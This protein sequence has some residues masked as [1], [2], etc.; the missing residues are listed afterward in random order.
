MRTLAIIA[1]STWNIY[2]FRRPLLRAFKDLGW[3]VV[4]V[5]PSDKFLEQVP[6]HEFDDFYPLT[7]L[8]SRRA[9]FF[10][11]ISLIIELRKI[12]T[13][14]RPDLILSFTVKPNI[15]SALAKKDI[16]RQI[17]TVTGLGSGLISGGWRASILGKLYKLVSG[18]ID[19]ML[20]QNK[21]DRSFFI[22]NEWARFEDSA[23]VAGSGIDIEHF[24]PI[25]QPKTIDFL[26]V[27]RLMPDKGILEFAEAA[28]EALRKNDELNFAAIGEWQPSS[29][30]IDDHSYE[31][32]NDSG[33]WIK[34]L[35]FQNDIR[36][37]LAK[38]KWLV[39]PSRREG[40]SRAILE[41]LAMEIPVI[42]SD[43]PG[44]IE[45]IRNNDHGFLVPH[46]NT[47]KLTEAMLV[48]SNM[49]ESERASMG[50]KGRQYIVDNYRE[51]VVVNQY[52]NA[53]NTL[54]PAE[55]GEKLPA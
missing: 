43:V 29:G 52:L 33:S 24:T 49:S 47:V 55:Q 17:A 13:V 6:S 5:A 28:S 18:R 30:F 40:L 11:D 21:D 9:N 54:I 14:I 46:G 3:K 31:S 27:G 15:Y 48:A 22:S 10:Q 26:F 44:C 2:N 38:A 50:K 35:P 4:L 12:F 39:L 19:L 32:L 37:V 41:A 8:E 25:E 53:V 20:F 36:P 42:A 45:L 16:S 1:N 34:L 51:E 23:I 7:K